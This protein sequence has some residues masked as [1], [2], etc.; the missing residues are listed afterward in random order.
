MRSVWLRLYGRAICPALVG[1]YVMSKYLEYA[2]FGVLWLLTL[3]FFSVL[4]MYVFLFLFL[5]AN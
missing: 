5:L 4:M 1:G 3:I 2:V